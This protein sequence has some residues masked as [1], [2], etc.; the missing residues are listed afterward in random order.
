MQNCAFTLVESLLAEHTL[1]PESTQVSTPGGTSSTISGVYPDAAR[2]ITPV[3]VTIVATSP[4]SCASV[5]HTL[6]AR[7]LYEP[8]EGVQPFAG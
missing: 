2:L 4:C 5:K 8:P 3:C 6:F 1:P 7:T